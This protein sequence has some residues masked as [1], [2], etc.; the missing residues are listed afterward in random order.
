M[1]FKINKTFSS[2]INARSTFWNR[3]TSHA[4]LSWRLVLCRSDESFRFIRSIHGSGE[5]RK[6]W[7]FGLVLRR[8]LFL[9]NRERGVHPMTCLSIPRPTSRLWCALANPW[10]L[11][12][13]RNELLAVTRHCSERVTRLFADV[14]VPSRQTI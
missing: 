14:P 9:A 11:Q 4:S 7:F 3:A 8:L 2:R 5:A 6:R 1:Q 12:I 13:L 10:G